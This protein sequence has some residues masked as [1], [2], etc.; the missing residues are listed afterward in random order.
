MIF[1][2]LN[3]Y[4][5]FLVFIVGT[6][7]G[8]FYNVVILRTLS[9]ESIVF[10][11]SKC[12]KCG[13]KLKPW[14]NIPIISYL[15]LKG[16]CAFCKEK[17]SIQYPIV[18]LLTGL[19]FSFAYIKFGFNYVTLFV[20][21]CISCLI[22]MT[23]TDLKEK[24][25]ECIY[26]IIMAVASL[27]YAISAGGLIGLKDSLIG[28]VLG[29]LIIEIIA[30]LGYLFK[31]GRAMGEADSYVACAL[32]AA[33]GYHDILLVLLYSLAA[34]MI[35]ILPRFFYNRYKENDALT[36]FYSSLFFMSIA[37]S[38]YFPSSY[39][40]LAFLA[41]TGGLLAF[42]II[43]NIKDAVNLNYLPFVPALS[44]G[45]LYYIFFVL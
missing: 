18:E 12:P 11:P 39:W 35:F 33:V 21:F 15:F 26:A 30:R 44:A 16:K 28:A 31:K 5:L 38:F 1:D 40:V 17:I 2:S 41:L 24:I 9:G 3:L 23:V 43:K 20:L 14:H 6:C 45:F 29:F 13:N 22:I 7:L 27:I 19:L 42:T 36:I 10:P 4:I 34:S 37:L 32:G 25:V 8:S